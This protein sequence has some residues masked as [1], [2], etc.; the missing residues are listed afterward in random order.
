MQNKFKQLHKRLKML[1]KPSTDQLLKQVILRTIHQIKVI[2]IERQQCKRKSVGSIILEVD[3]ECE[4]ITHYKIGINGPSGKNICTG[5]QNACGC[6]H[7]EERAVL[8]YLKMRKRNSHRGI[9]ILITTYVP[10]TNCANLIIDSGIIDAVIYE[11]PIL[12][13]IPGLRTGDQLLKSSLHF[14]SLKE[15]EEDIDNKLMKNLLGIK[16]D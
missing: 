2:A 13:L 12:N 9:T 4:L 15:I 6:S 14:W 11:H 3:K 8:N 5:I 7:S 1:G 16:D 10:C